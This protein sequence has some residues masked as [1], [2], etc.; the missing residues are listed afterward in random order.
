M[1]AKDVVITRRGRSKKKEKQDDP[2]SNREGKAAWM[3]NRRDDWRLRPPSRWITNFTPLNAPLDQ[4]LMQ[5]RD[6]PALTWPIKSKSDLIKRLRN[7]Y[8]RFHCNHGH[9]ISDYYDLK[10]QIEAFIRQGKLQQFLE[11]E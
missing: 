7:K 2:H 4:V 6:D 1:N 10:Q 11:K 9:D 5:I 8:C 3:S